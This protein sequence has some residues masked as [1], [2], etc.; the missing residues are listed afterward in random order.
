MKESPVPVEQQL[1]GRSGHGTKE[2]NF[3]YLARIEPRLSSPKALSLL[4]VHFSD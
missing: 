4:N 3:F 2:K 1:E